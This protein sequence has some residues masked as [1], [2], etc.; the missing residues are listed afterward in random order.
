[1]RAETENV[2]VYVASDGARYYN[3]EQ[4]ELH[5]IQYAKDTKPVWK[6][7][8]DNIED[9][10]NHDV[11]LF[12]ITSQDDYDF[13]LATKY[14]IPQFASGLT[15]KF[16]DAGEDWYMLSNGVGWYTFESLTS[17]FQRKKKELD[18]FEQTINFHI[19]KV[20]EEREKDA[21][22]KGTR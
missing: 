2:T 15:E 22:D 11:T 7:R 9:I 4:C 12:Y 16:E 6:Y 20:N 21:E 13:A 1:M 19:A 18:D 3:R 10:D 14:C 5:E 17:Y 8:I